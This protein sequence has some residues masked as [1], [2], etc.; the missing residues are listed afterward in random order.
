M[1]TRKLKIAYVFIIA[2]ASVI[3][4]TGCGN[5]YEGHLADQYDM[6]AAV[7]GNASLLLLK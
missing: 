6:Q 1:K 4:T 5:K 7:R 2:I 3:I